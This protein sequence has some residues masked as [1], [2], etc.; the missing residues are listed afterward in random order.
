MQASKTF[1]ERLR[2][3]MDRAGLTQRDL[4][5][6][7]GAGYPGINRVLQGKQNPTIEMAD[8]LADAV[9]IPLSKLLENN[10]R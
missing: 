3:A 2:E 4:A 6:K 7:V 10:S 5:K 9:G 1:R 8:K